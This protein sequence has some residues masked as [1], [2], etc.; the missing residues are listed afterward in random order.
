MPS[1]PQELVEII[2]DYLYDDHTSLKT[3]SLVSQSWVAPSRYH[4]FGSVNIG[5]DRMG[6]LPDFLTLLQSDSCT[7]RRSL[8]NFGL[9]SKEE[10][11]P[12]FVVR[13]QLLASI[14]AQLPTLESFSIVWVALFGQ[15]RTQDLPTVTIRRLHIEGNSEDEAR[16]LFTLALFARTTCEEISIAD[17]PFFEAWLT[18]RVRPGLGVDSSPE[19]MDALA[20]WHIPSITVFNHT[21]SWFAQPGSVYSALQRTAVHRGIHTLDVQVSGD[22]RAF[23]RFMRSCGEFISTLRLDATPTWRPSVPGDN[24]TIYEALRYCT[25]LHTSAVPPLSTVLS[26]LSRKSSLNPHSRMCLPPFTI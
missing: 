17:T 20:Q 12:P 6:S 2:V 1:I 4:L 14:L 22:R 16:Y 8:R 13:A 7:F 25:N 21:S 18:E 24:I 10:Y 5:H 9:I 3:C 11:I 26:A 15:L 19:L 23:V